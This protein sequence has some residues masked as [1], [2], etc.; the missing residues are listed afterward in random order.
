MVQE[1]GAEVEVGA[2]YRAYSRWCVANGLR[3]MSAK[4]VGQQLDRRGYPSGRDS[5]ARKRFGL[6]LSD[7]GVRLAAGITPV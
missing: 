6:R 7:A 3:P 1:V 4:R 5:G 2:L